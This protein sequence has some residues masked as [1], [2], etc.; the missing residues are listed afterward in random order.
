[1][2]K[3]YNIFESYNDNKRCI[4]Y[5]FDGVLHLSVYPNSIEPIRYFDFNSW[6]PS[7]NIH[8]LLKKQYDNGCKI[9]VV[10]ARECTSLMKNILYKY[11]DKYEL[12]VDDIVLTDRNNKID[13][14]LKYDVIRHYDD[15]IMMKYELENSGIEFIFVQND[16]II[17]RYI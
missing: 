8:Q 12:P 10:S 6:K 1:M 13:F 15:N 17:E 14:L 7:V 9:I 4:S 3:K 2:I 5:D 16:K 11:I